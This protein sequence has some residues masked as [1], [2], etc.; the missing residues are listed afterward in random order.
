MSAPGRITRL[1]ELGRAP[2]GFWLDGRA[3]QGMAGDTVLTA[4]L[5]SAPALR[6][7]E[8]GPEQRAGL[9]PPPPTFP[10]SLLCRPGRVPG[11]RRPAG[12]YGG[13]RP[14]SDPALLTLPRAAPQGDCRP[15]GFLHKNGCL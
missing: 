9:C 5:L 10:G 8:F 7:A 13:L 2:V 6:Q 4:V 3:L 14:G 11:P 1:A 15:A 12:L